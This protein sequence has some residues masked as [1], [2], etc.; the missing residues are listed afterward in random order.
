[1]FYLNFFAS[2]FKHYLFISDQKYFLILSSIDTNGTL[3][4]QKLEIRTKSN[5]N[6]FCLIFLIE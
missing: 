2:L 1:M 5:Q 6:L 4:T 3:E